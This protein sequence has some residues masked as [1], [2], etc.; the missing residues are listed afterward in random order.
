[1]SELSHSMDNIMAQ[2]KEHVFGMSVWRP[3][4]QGP[5]CRWSTVDLSRFVVDLRERHLDYWACGGTLL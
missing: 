2:I 4:H 5:S 1:M 3:H